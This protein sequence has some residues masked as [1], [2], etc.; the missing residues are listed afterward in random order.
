MADRKITHCQ[1]AQNFDA[2]PFAHFVA[3][4]REGGTHQFKL[5]RLVE[6]PYQHSRTTIERPHY[7]K[8]LAVA[9]ISEAMD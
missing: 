9:R 3:R 5:A 2:H 7:R 4:I 1:L 6:V 8:L